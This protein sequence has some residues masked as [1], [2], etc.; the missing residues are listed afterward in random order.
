MGGQGGRKAARPV[1]AGPALL[2]VRRNQELVHVLDGRLAAQ[3]LLGDGQV[4][5]PV[6]AEREVGEG[7]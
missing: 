6:A 3:Y 5:G 2:A 4:R 1:V 7:G